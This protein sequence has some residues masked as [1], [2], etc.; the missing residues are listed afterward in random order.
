MGRGLEE[1]VIYWYVI[2]GHSRVAKERIEEGGGGGVKPHTYR[3]KQMDPK[4]IFLFLVQQK[5]TRLRSFID[6]EHL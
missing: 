6:A 3:T 4:Y 2:D 1:G 5:G